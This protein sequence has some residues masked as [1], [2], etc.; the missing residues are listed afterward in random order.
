MQLEIRKLITIP[1][2]ERLKNLKDLLL[3]WSKVDRLLR[4]SPRGTSG[5]YSWL[6][7][8]GRSLRSVTIWKSLLWSTIIPSLSWGNLE[9]NFGKECVKT[10][11]C[12]MNSSEIQNSASVAQP[13]GQAWD[14][15]HGPTEETAERVICMQM[16]W[17]LQQR[18][19]RSSESCN[20]PLD[21]R[22]TGLS[23]PICGP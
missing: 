22:N 16:G 19:K 5:V 17:L 11:R 23:G 13:Q 10:Y 6:P 7:C 14:W 3:K 9:G 15:N 21:L 4:A 8:P 18:H 12:L 20:S 1:D 2:D